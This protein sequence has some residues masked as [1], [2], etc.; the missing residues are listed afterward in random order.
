MV[1]KTFPLPPA[2]FTGIRFPL[3]LLFSSLTS[4]P[5]VTDFQPAVRDN[6]DLIGAVKRCAVPQDGPRSC[7]KA[8]FSALWQAKPLFRNILHISPL[9]SKILRDFPPN[10]VIPIDRGEGVPIN[11]TLLPSE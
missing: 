1:G 7:P 3:G 9:N 6:G 11:S 8:I 10:H 4:G 2:R 5:C